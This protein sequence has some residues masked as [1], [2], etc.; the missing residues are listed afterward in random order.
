[1]AFFRG[2]G[3]FSHVRSASLHGDDRERGF[4]TR[5]IPGAVL[6]SGIPSG[7][8]L[9]C[10]AQVYAYLKRLGYVVTRV[11]QPT[12]SYPIPPPYPS[13]VCAVQRRS[14]VQMILHPL[15]FI[16]SHI[17]SLFTHPLNWWQPIRI[18]PLL[19]INTNYRWSGMLPDRT[20]L[21]ASTGS[22]FR[23]LRFIP[24]GHGVPLKAKESRPPAQESPYAHFFNVYKPNTPYKKT[25]PPVPDFAI[26][27]VR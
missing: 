27:V 21:T 4:D 10:D 22:I 1:M 17:A 8:R 2:R 3:G 12:P 19:G 23:S 20:A 16:L 15:R 24:H 18:S 26:S 7:H 9:S 5:K 14:L 13:S 6:L 25:D 11:K